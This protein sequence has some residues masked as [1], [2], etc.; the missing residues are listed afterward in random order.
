[1]RALIGICLSYPLY[2]HGYEWQAWT[3]FI[4]GILRFGLYFLGGNE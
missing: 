4:V 2:D 1:M 3:L